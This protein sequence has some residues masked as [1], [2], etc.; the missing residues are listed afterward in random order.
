[1]IH[2]NVACFLPRSEQEK[3]TVPNSAVVYAILG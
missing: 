2:G 1:L 3:A